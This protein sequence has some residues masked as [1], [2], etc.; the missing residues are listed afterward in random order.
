MSPSAEHA[1]TAPTR[2]SLPWLSQ[3]NTYC[4]MEP[5]VGLAWQ[6]VFAAASGTVAT[7]AHRAV[8]FLGLW[9]GY[10]AD[11]WLD[12]RS[13]LRPFPEQGLTDR[14][15]FF[16]KYRRGLAKLWLVVFLCNALIA[17][18]FLTPLELISGM[19]VL[20]ATA[21]YLT[22]V[23]KRSTVRWLK[24][25]LAALVF[26]AGTSVFAWSYQWNVELL[27]AQLTLTLLAIFN[28]KATSYAEQGVDLLSTTTQP[29]TTEDTPL[30]L[31]LT[32]LFASLCL[33]L[34][35]LGASS[36]SLV[37]LAAASALLCSALIARVAQR[38]VD[39]STTHSLLDLVL[40]LPTLSLAI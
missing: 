36:W 6:E 14:H 26:V 30:R 5:A 27:A 4:V 1:V 25:P 13:V 28:L 11:R 22:I 34:P 15:R 2:L 16:A 12:A 19:L 37:G 33:L 21:A 8:V 23:Q 31:G 29:E 17:V 38:Y 24:S 7:P 9:L 20:V 3:L 18:T 32:I 39:P 35:A 10:S 40:F